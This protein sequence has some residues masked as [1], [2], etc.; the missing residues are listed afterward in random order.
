MHEN[1]INLAK[2]SSHGRIIT[3]LSPVEKALL[4]AN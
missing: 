4:Y 3:Y 1:D 2:N